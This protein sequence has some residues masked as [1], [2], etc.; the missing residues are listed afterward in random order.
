[1]DSAVIERGHLHT[2]LVE[3]AVENHRIP[4]E[5]A[6]YAARAAIERCASGCVS[7]GATRRRTEAYFWAV[8]RRRALATRDY[9]ELSAR[10][11]IE[12]VVKDLRS[13]GR[14]DGEILSELEECWIGC[15]PS[16]VMDEYRFR[17]SAP[18][19]VA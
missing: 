11:L 9:P 13:A 19:A 14:S 6:V 16:T 12:S 2:S 7:N 15:V 1:M 3:S 18:A 17:L 5:L 10:F 4:R 8:I